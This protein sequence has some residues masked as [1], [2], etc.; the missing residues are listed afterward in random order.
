MQFGRQHSIFLLTAK[1]IAE[2]G[3]ESRMLTIKLNVAASIQ[4]NVE[5]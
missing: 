1:V 4:T 5:S 3:T 2:D